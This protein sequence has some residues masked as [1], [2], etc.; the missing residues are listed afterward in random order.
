M[1]W[2]QNFLC[3][4]F[5]ERYGITEWYQNECRIYLD[6]YPE[7][8][9]LRRNWF[10]ENRVGYYFDMLKIK[11]QNYINKKREQEAIYFERRWLRRN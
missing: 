9:E 5:I 11:F 7:Q 8:E 4:N 3:K 1:T 6:E 10:G 2:I